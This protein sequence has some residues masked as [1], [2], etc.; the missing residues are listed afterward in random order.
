MNNVYIFKDAKTHSQPQIKDKYS[1]FFPRNGKRKTD[2]ITILK[3]FTKRNRLSHLKKRENE[4]STVSK[5]DLL[6]V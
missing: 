1:Y 2:H 6:C 3:I 5:V 4:K